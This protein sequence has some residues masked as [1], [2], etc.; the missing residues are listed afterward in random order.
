MIYDA[1]NF[2]VYQTEANIAISE[3]LLVSDKCI[4]KMFCG[5]GKSLLMRYCKINHEKKLVVYVFP[6]LA[7]I[8]QFY[9][10]YF[11]KYRDF[12]LENI[13]KICSENEAT[14]NTDHIRKF[15]SRQKIKKIICV[16]Y[17]SFHLLKDSLGINQ[18]IN[19]CIFDEAHHI[20]G[21]TYQKL[22]FENDFCEKQIFFTATPKNAN[23][24]IMYDR[25]R[26]DAGMCGKLVYDYSYLRGMNEGYLNPFEIRIAMSTEN[27][28]KSVYESMARAILSTGN[29][30]VL[31]FHSDVNTERDTS[32]NNFV[33][34][35]EFTLVF[36][37][38][39]KKEFPNNEKYKK[40]KMIGLS[41]N[42]NGEARKEIL[43]TFD[44]VKDNE[45]MVLSSCRTVGEGIDTKNANMV[46]FVDPKTSYIDILQNMGRIV[47]KVFGQTKPNSTILIPCWVDKA[48][49]LECNGDKEKCDEVIRQDMSESGNFN[50]ILN[51]LSALKQE[52]EDIY[53]ICLHYPDTYSPQEVKSNLEKQGY[54]VDEQVGD[55]GLM[56]TIEHLLDSDLN[57]D[58]LEDCEN[59]EEMIMKIA[60]DN[61]VCIEVF[62]HSLENPI[63]RYNSES[64]EF[65][66]LYKDPEEDEVYCPIILEKSKTKRNAHELFKEPTRNNRCS[67]SVHVNP[68][69]K[70][71]W[72]IVG[73][74]DITKDICSCII[75]CEV[76]DNTNE[77]WLLNCQQADDYMNC[78]KKKP[79]NTDAD[80]AIRRLGSWI[81][82]NQFNYKNKI[83]VMNETKIQR[84]ELLCETHTKLMTTFTDKWDLQLKQAY[85]YISDNQKR[86]TASVKESNETR[87]LNNWINNQVKNY[88]FKKD[89]MKYSGYRGKWEEFIR[90]NKQYFPTVDDVWHIKLKEA[91]AYISRENK[92]PSLI[93]NPLLTKEKNAQE[94][95]MACWLYEQVKLS[96]HDKQAVSR[97]VAWT[98]FTEKHKRHFT[99]LDYEWYKTLEHADKFISRE[100]KR[101]SAGINTKEEEK[102]LAIWINQNNMKYKKYEHSNG[103][104]N[105]LLANSNIRTAWKTFVEK[106]KQYFMPFDEKWDTILQEAKKY[107]VQMLHKLNSSNDQQ[108]DEAKQL[109]VEVEC[110]YIKKWLEHQKTNYNKYIC[111]KTQITN[112]INASKI[113]T[114]EGRKW[115]KWE[116][117]IKWCEALNGGTS[118]SSI[119]E[120]LKEDPVVVT[121]NKPKKK[122]MKLKQPSIS[123]T[124]GEKRQR[125]TSELSVLHQRYKTLNS[126][127][128]NKE[129]K[130]NPESWTNYHA[131]SEENGKS[132]PE[133]EI[134]R[135]RVIRKLNETKTKRQ[136]LVVDMGCGRAQIAQHYQ[137]DTRFKFI[138][139][140]HISSN[141]TVISCDISHTP[142]EDNSVEICILSLSMWGSNCH[143]YILEAARI[144][145]SR[146]E[147]YIIEPTKRW[148]EKDAAGNNIKGE[149]GGKL[150]RLLEEYGFQI[151]EESV[152]KFC[153][154][155]CIR[156]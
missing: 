140:D 20:V 22:I 143:D 64:S 13:L 9:R 155:V 85:Q 103:D 69:V 111:N 123:E 99:S 71:L 49:Y 119:S 121:K 150:R 147:L 55:G 40:V 72:S 154:F 17:N 42:I 32:V 96:R 67:I 30:R 108:K 26:I 89:R 87:K 142:L 128:L 125:I 56:E 23:G 6:S 66:P 115:D 93:D 88:D 63:E 145:E 133:D 73:D 118:I 25:E 76:V 44:A 106:Y 18:K 94:K 61:N 126:Q 3:E 92:R 116:E 82:N 84:W 110:K 8:D 100:K 35:D 46:V 41:S 120:D 28:N 109:S 29:T 11:I 58:D 47:R 112:E 97:T 27:T 104:E 79:S 122:S 60:E 77:T 52:D 2:R 102:Q 80:Q 48:K 148:S 31:T 136:K 135:N 57:Y 5:A 139:Y 16:T 37:E 101:P 113:Q 137:N 141:D 75:D 54:A 10:D 7:L 130:E 83:H 105:A 129:F 24:I 151:L 81:K 78:R 117:F 33:N 98:D 127:T 43:A 144:L 59:A 51:V 156:Y 149:E 132:F 19:V 114:K 53:D 107:K 34:D 14:T 138:N 15:L 131:K 124:P 68:D 146:G 90:I 39:Q 4:V 70:V 65:I 95:K 36:K 153:L 45:V 62:T 38:I 21:H 50:S 1:I 134:P 86:P 12:P 91:D 152:E 74:I